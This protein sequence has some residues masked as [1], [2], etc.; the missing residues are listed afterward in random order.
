M[1]M[2][3]AL[4]TQASAVP[5]EGTAATEAA[6]ESYSTLARAAWVVAFLAA[7]L[8]FEQISFIGPAPP[9]VLTPWNPALGLCVVAV[10]WWGPRILPFVFIAPI[11]TNI[12]TDWPAINLTYAAWVGLMG[13]A[14][15]LAVTASAR[16]LSR[17]V[18]NPL[19]KNKLA[20]VLL[21]CL[22]IAL[23]F[24]AVNAFVLEQMQMLAVTESW[25]QQLEAVMRIWVGHVIGIFIVTPLC[26][27]ALSLRRP[28]AVSV[29][30]VLEIAAQA[31][32]VA[33]AVWLAF[34]ENPL[35]ASRYFYIVFLP[36]I[37][38]VL[39]WGMNG[40][41]IMNAFV[42][43][44]MVVSLSWAGHDSVDVTL[45][46]AFLVVLAASSFTLGLAVDQSRAS[47][48][49][50]RVREGE[51]AASL[52]VAA[53]GELAGT[54]A[55]ELGHPLGAIS[56]YAA[57][58]DHVIA[59][60]APDSP[61]AAGISRKLS[62]EITR[63][64][65]TL[66]RLRDFFRTGSL[67]LER[68]DMGA[69]VREAVTLLHDRLEVKAISPSIV[70]QGGSNVVLADRVQIHA[71]IHNVLTNAVDALRL[72]SAED[73]MIAIT[74]SRTADGVTLEIDDSG[75]GVAADVRDHIFEP[76]TTTKKD[77]LGLGLSMSRSVV[78]AHG[79]RI[80]LEESRLGGA[81][82]VI[83]LPFEPPKK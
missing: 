53:T 83:T 12:I 61:E 23:A 8:G 79:G 18:P 54:L 3:R 30:V 78:A 45:F 29:K 1:M 21:T 31:T 59:K 22:P 71:V 50:L 73:R 32:F 55:H 15:T 20:A 66:H 47:A 70:I 65:D 7:Y 39:R 62:R 16:R 24:A 33:A 57:A 44:S 68:V 14:E 58:L 19:L 63:A 2:E 34:G 72:A 11:L 42:Q 49:Q 26:W 52:K 74:V 28:R 10:M 17:A 13:A 81:R 56:N 36:M 35:R 43:I 60:V 80:H 5:L 25:T 27:L 4:T 64:T 75:V 51:L 77:G 69:L 82:F 67:A 9:L 37:W 38:I 76:L 6:R 48:Q 40:A 46:Q 41:I